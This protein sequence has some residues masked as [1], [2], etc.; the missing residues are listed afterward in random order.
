MFSLLVHVEAVSI[1]QPAFDVNRM[2]GVGDNT[3]GGI[4]NAPNALVTKM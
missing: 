2:A 3:T 4:A 1:G